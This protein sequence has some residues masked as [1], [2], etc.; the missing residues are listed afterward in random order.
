MSRF[1]AAAFALA[2]VLSA[3]AE[4]PKSKEATAAELKKQIADLEAVLKK[5]TAEFEKVEAEATKLDA[6]RKKLIEARDKKIKEL[7]DA[8]DKALAPQKEKAATEKDKAVKVRKA[9]QEF[10]DAHNA[11]VK[12]YKASNDP[13]EQDVLGKRINEE[14]E[15]FKLKVEVLKKADAAA[16][17]ADD[18]Y[19]KAAEG[20]RAEMDRAARAGDLALLPLM[21]EQAQLLSVLT[22][23]QDDRDRAALDV[24]RLKEKLA[25]LEG[26]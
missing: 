4:D 20:P 15:E 22:K 23:L 7:R 19:L 24:R 14:V 9:L 10:V 17:A 3:A 12:K 13:K 8:A 25:V 11:L 16:K 1:V 5:K 21:K 2:A 6:E 18:E 26:K